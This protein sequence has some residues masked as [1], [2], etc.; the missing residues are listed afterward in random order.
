MAERELTSFL[1]SSYKATNPIQGA[2]MT[3]QRPHLELGL[4]FKH[5]NVCVWGGWC[6]VHKETAMPSIN[7]VRT[8]K[9][10]VESSLQRPS[11]W[12]PSPSR[13]SD[14]FKRVFHSSL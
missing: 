9:Q 10:L 2:L 4:V 3:F 13:A 7:L 12:S 11:D 5:M 1:A 14:L 8:Y 6:L